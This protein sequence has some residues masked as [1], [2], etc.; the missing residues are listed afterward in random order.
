MVVKARPLDVNI[1]I[2]LAGKTQIPAEMPPLQGEPLVKQ[3]PAS[4]LNM[5]IISE[6]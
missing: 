6:H 2:E 5:T 4:I 1:S 3:F